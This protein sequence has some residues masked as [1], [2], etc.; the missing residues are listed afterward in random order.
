MKKVCYIGFALLFFCNCLYADGPWTQKKGAFFFKIGQSWINADQYFNRNGEIIDITK[1]S[2]YTTSIYPEYGISPKITAVAYLP[3]FTRATLNKRTAPDGTVITEGDEL[4]G[5]GDV[6][7]GLKYEIYKKNS[8]VL[9]TSLHFGIPSGNPSGGS[10][11]LL[12]TGDGEFNQLLSLNAGYSFYPRPFY[13]SASVA[14]NNR[15]Q[16]FSDEYRIGGELGYTY[17]KFTLI[18]R[19]LNVNSFFNGNDDAL[20]GN[21]LFNNNVEYFSFTPEVLYQCNEKVGFSAGIGTAFS[22]KSILANPIFQ[23]GVFWKW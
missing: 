10:T 16:N 2:L 21:G 22:G 17:K 20:S 19:F 1:T 11:E 23:I 7:L 6:K 9:S 15:T 12:Q 8:F 4:N 3:V 5:I 14:F 13:A 18:L